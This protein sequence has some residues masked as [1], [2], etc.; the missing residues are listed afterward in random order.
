M[1]V[2]LTDRHV[3]EHIHV[4]LHTEHGNPFSMQP[5]RDLLPHMA[6]CQVNLDWA[7]AIRQGVIQ[8]V[9]ALQHC[10]FLHMQAHK[11]WLCYMADCH[12]DLDWPASGAQGNLLCMHTWWHGISHSI[13]NPVG[14]CEQAWPCLMQLAENIP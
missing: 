14:M 10:N 8:N 9:Q 2:Q 11:N 5:H 3:T 7:A 12:P 1:K 13:N 4:R 6:V